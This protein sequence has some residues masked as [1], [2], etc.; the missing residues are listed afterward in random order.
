MSRK[1]CNYILGPWY[2]HDNTFC[3]NLQLCYWDRGNPIV[4]RNGVLVGV[5]SIPVG[6]VESCLGPDI[7]VSVFPY[8]KWIESIASNPN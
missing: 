2:V 3:T 8:V 7:N 5:A 6:T 4:D 1:E